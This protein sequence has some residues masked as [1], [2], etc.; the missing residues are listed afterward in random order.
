MDSFL[1]S[2][3][4]PIRIAAFESDEGVDGERVQR[5]IRTSENRAVAQH[6][7]SPTILSSTPRSR[8]PVVDSRISLRRNTHTVGSPYTVPPIRGAA[9]PA[10]SISAPSCRAPGYESSMSPTKQNG[11]YIAR[12]CA[13]QS[14]LAP[15]A[16]SSS[17]QRSRPPDIESR[18]SRSR[19]RPA[20]GSAGALTSNRNFAP[21]AFSSSSQ[22]STPPAIESRM[23]PH[24]N[25]L[26][27]GSPGIV[28][29]NRSF[30]PSVVPAARHA[31]CHLAT[32][33]G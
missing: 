6:A 7:V 19:N 24:R 20:V 26:T 16:I 22:R 23:G 12:H 15:P 32:S 13:M 21:Q 18:M 17:T 14:D 28:P 30:A 2:P 9:S 25:R 8:Q 33:Q 31:A 5:E 10:I 3:C 1:C 27:V 11:G 4:S 29:S